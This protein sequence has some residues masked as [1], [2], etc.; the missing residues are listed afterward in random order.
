[1]YNYVTER[2]AGYEELCRTGMTFVT[3]RSNPGQQTV[4]CGTYSS[5][6]AQKEDCTASNGPKH[7]IWTLT[8]LLITCKHDP[9]TQDPS[10]NLP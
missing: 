6:L 5:G 7:M 8:D 1:M 2:F 3:Y 9:V 10:K 4:I